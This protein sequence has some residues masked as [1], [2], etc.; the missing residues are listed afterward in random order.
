MVV[1]IVDS[2]NEKNDESLRLVIV[3][4]VM[5]GCVRLL[6][7]IVQMDFQFILI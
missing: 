6:L 7:V 1:A 4:T 5:T 3:S 2:K